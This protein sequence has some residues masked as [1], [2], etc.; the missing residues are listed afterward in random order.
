[1]TGFCRLVLKHLTVV[2]WLMDLHWGTAV[3][4]LAVGWGAREWTFKLP[5]PNV[6]RC[7]CDYSSTG[8]SD[9]SGGSSSL[10]IYFL[11]LVGLIVVFSN[12]ALALKVFFQDSDTGANKSICFDVKG[13]GKSKGGIYG[14]KQGLSITY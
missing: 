13:T 11:V 7:H 3:V 1:M 14:A 12:T 9:T 8:P 6:C 10:V 2:D 5:E 4:G